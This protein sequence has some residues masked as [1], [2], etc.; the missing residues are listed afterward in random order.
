MRLHAMPQQP[1]MALPG[2]GEV[3]A[4]VSLKGFG[5]GLEL[6]EAHVKRVVS[7]VRRRALSAGCDGAFAGGA[8]GGA[9]E[10]LVLY[11]D[12]DPLAQDSFTAVVMRLAFEMP[13]AT[14]C[15][16]VTQ[17]AGRFESFE[18]SWGEVLQ[19]RD[20]TV[21]Q[22]AAAEGD[23]AAHGVLAHLFFQPDA[24][25]CVGGGAVVLEELSLLEQRG[26]LPKAQ[27]VRVFPFGRYKGGRRGSTRVAEPSSLL[28]DSRCT[29]LALTD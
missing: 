7:E 29:M 12:G 27:S 9:G 17:G 5:S 1:L 8:D 24:T 6:S 15:A 22:T 19:G 26:T 21:F 20:V 28:R 4:V 3:T 2:F 18:R 11:W 10:G 25:V 13:A 14:L 16:A 23:Y